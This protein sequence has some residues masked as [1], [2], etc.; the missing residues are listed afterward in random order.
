MGF[1]VPPLVVRLAAAAVIFASAEALVFRS[2]LYNSV[3]DPMSAAGGIL[4]NVRNEQERARVGPQ[5]VTVGD[6]RMGIR[7]RVANRLMAETGY[8]F[9]NIAV[10][11]ASVR[12]WYY[13]LREIDPGANRYAA[14]V[15]PTESYEDEDHEDYSAVPD[16]HYL[17]PLLRIADAF[18]YASSFTGWERRWEAFRGCVLKGY[19]YRRDFQDFLVRHKWRLKLLASVRESSADWIYQAGWGTK[20]L[21]GLEVDWK[22]RKIV[23]PEGLTPGE[24]QAVEDRLFR[25]DPP[26]T[27]WQAAFR[28]RWL[29]AIVRRY[30]G[31][32]TR[33][34]FIRLP[35][36][37]LPLPLSPIHRTSTIREFAAEPHVTVAP[38]NLFDELE[39]PEL[40]GDQMHLNGAGGDRFSLML[41]RTVPAILAVRH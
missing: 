1:R 35:R 39:R 20:S 27:G 26:P 28:R 14:I 18:G 29:G 36:G 23:F 32:A 15:I 24:R 22:A 3:I 31:S 25:A 19:A 13:M 34:I 7:A 21:K 41:A 6:S 8:T 11:G 37:P 16:V 38:E 4:S 17:A 40:F 12:S 33:V 30:R 9:G 5:I 10:P 2:G